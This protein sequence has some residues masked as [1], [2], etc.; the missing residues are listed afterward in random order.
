VAKGSQVQAKSGISRSIQEE[1]KKWAGAPAIS[2]NN[3]LRSQV[4][5]SRLPETEQKIKELEKKLTELQK[6]SELYLKPQQ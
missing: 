4:M 5:V 6:V 3:N 2:Y 1:N